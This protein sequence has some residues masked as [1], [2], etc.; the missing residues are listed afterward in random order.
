MRPESASRC[1]IQQ[2]SKFRGRSLPIPALGLLLALG[3]AVFA[4]RAWVASRDLSLVHLFDPDANTE[5]S[6]SPITVGA[7]P[8]ALASD[9]ADAE[10]P[11]QVFVANSGSNNVSVIAAGSPG[12]S[13]TLAGGGTYGTFQTPS[14]L[15]RVPSSPVTIAVT[16]WKSTTGQT[17]H[18]RSTLRFLH[19]EL[20]SIVDDFRDPSPTARYQGVVWTPDG[21]GL[22]LWIADDGDGGIVVVRVPGTIPFLLP[23]TLHYVGSQ[24]FADFIYDDAATPS[25]LIAPRRLGTDGSVVVAVDSASSKVTI[26]DALYAADAESSAVLANVDLPAGAG[27]GVDV[28]VRGGFAYVSSTGVPNLHRIDLGTRTLS[29]GSIWQVPSAGGLGATVGGSTLLVGSGAGENEVGRYDILNWPPAVLPML[30]GTGRSRP[31]AMYVS[32]P[33][34]AL[35]PPGSGPPFTISTSNV[36]YG[37]HVSGGCGLLGIE[38]LLVLGLVSRLRRRGRHTC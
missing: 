18:G 38:V 37:T 20:H 17:L 7:G 25:F 16:D 6:A 33:N 28:L 31:F 10:G 14:G 24:E 2:M 35:P 26:L 27:N 15:A 30:A 8:V 13:A 29:L 3:A 21:A 9:K 34:A 12:V 36:P 5:E 11:W 23:K 1:K 32:P 19:P 22:R 4:E